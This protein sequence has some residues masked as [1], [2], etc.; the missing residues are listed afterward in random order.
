MI[1]ISAG[2]SIGPECSPVGELSHTITPPQDISEGDPR[3]ERL[4]LELIDSLMRQAREVG[5]DTVKMSEM[6]VFT[7]HCCTTHFATAYRCK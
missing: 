2:S 7:T 6:Q 4:R 1:L 3:I 5:A